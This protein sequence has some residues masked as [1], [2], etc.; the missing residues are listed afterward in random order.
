MLR[1]EITFD[2][3]VR[4]LLLLGGLVLTFFAL[5]YLSG[6]LLPFCIAL[7]YCFPLFVS[8]STD[9]G[10]ATVCFALCSRCFW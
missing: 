6:V 2:R 1:R 4:G 7:I 9:A 8:C 5:K 3:F 10:F